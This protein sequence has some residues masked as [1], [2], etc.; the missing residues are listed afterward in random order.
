MHVSCAAVMSAATMLSEFCLLTGERSN[1]NAVRDAHPAPL[2]QGLNP[3]DDSV[4]AY[5]DS[6]NDA[7]M[8]AFR[9]AREQSPGPVISFSH[10]L[11]RRANAGGRG[12]A[13]CGGHAAAEELGSAERLSLEAE[14]SQPGGSLGG[15]NQSHVPRL[16]S[17]S[18]SIFVMSPGISI[19]ACH[20]MELCP[21]KRFLFYPKL[22][23]AVG[24]DFL[25]R[26]VQDLKPDV[27]V[28]GAS[29]QAIAGLQPPF[30]GAAK[31]CERRIVR[32]PAWQRQLLAVSSVQCMSIIA[33]A[34]GWRLRRSCAPA[35]RQQCRVLSPRCP[36]FSLSTTSRG[37]M[38]L[39]SDP[40]PAL[41]TVQTH[42]AW[43]QTLDGIR[44]IQV[45]H[46]WIA[47]QTECD[48]EKVTT[49]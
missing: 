34:H 45:T 7:P 19:L 38:E 29:A 40:L 37:R 1:P 16:G 33:D 10:F 4:A 32:S 18:P 43:D 24:S 35:R 2:T 23:K 41:R 30:G 17:G 42:F 27:H 48:L 26:R 22:P 15:N 6:L 36:A 13:L 44:Y 39:P 11:P 21:E 5:F 31:G 25:R 47:A 9:A 12:G 14:G 49:T 20:R 3:L 8:A 28:F 46:P